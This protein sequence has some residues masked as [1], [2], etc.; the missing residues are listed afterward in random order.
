[1]NHTTVCIKFW[2]QWIKKPAVRVLI[3]TPSC[4]CNQIRQLNNAGSLRIYKYRNFSQISEVAPCGSVGPKIMSQHLKGPF[5]F[6]FVH[7]YKSTL[8]FASSI[9]M[10]LKK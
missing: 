7:Y 2:N 8:I 4:P 1:M 3:S 6:R 10:T 9:V 5:I